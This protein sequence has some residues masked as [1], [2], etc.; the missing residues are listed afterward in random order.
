MRPHPL[1][2][3]LLLA[4][5]AGFSFAAVSTYDFT[6]HLDRQVHG[7][8]CSFLPGLTPTETSGHSGCHVTLMSPYSSVM[9][10]S[11]WGGVPIA[12]PAMGVFAFL[13]FWAL[14]LMI[15]GHELDPRA[16][17]FTLAATA[18]PAGASLMMGYISLA[19]LH[20]ACKLC[21]GIYSASA[22]AFAS[23]ALAFLRARGTRVAGGVAQVDL[24]ALGLT[25]GVGLLFVVV[26]VTTYATSAPDF[27]RYVGHCGKLAQTEGSSQVLVPLGAQDRP[28]SMIEVLD[29]LCPSCRGFEDRFSR[30]DA[31]LELSRKLLLFPLDNACN[32][33]VG[34]SLHP[35]ACAVSEAMLCAG[36][37]A[38]DVLAWSFQ[39]QESVID[40]TKAD[41]KAAARLVGAAFPE[42]ASCLGSASTKAKLNLVLRYAVK[43][44][45][46]VLTPQVFVEGVRLCDEDTD[47]GLDF[48]LPRLIAYA[49]A[50]PAGAAT[51]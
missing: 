47:L 33:M 42:L 28:L 14:W 40:A 38:G 16:S 15:R 13:A 1:T 27:S 39:N 17:A 12:L 20:A 21:I 48:A 26:P 22:L 45:L 4:A 37:R 18:L 24:G 32:W 44:R 50:N 2:A 43:N 31:R 19:E 6:A 36:A 23:A 8:H 46:Q 5:L 7:I 35:G 11:V 3:L 51:H 10:S 9:R 29:P 30:M 49:R 34:D 41:P 25:F